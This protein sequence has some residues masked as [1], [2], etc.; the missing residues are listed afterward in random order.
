MSIL[1]GRSAGLQSL[2]MICVAG[3]GAGRFAAAD[4]PRRP[5]ILFMLADDKY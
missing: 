5:N 1:I 4:A 3:L 2:L